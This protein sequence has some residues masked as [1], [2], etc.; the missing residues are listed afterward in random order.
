MS[1]YSILYERLDQYTI[2][3]KFS[4]ITKMAFRLRI[5]SIQAAVV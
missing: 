1:V 3:A 2:N 4:S 5:R